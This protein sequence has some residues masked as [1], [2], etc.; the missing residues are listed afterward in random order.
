MEEKT[1]KGSKNHISE[2]TA[3]PSI[4]TSGEEE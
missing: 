1:K 2:T 3:Y 4:I